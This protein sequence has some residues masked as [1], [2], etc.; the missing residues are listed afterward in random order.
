[1][2]ASPFPK[3]GFPF[4]SYPEQPLLVLCKRLWWGYP[5]GAANPRVTSPAG[6]LVTFRV[7]GELP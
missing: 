2:V 4:P 1:M 6:L 7:L 3:G 5:C